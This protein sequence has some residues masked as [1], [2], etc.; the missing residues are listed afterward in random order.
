VTILYGNIQYIHKSLHLLQFFTFRLT[1]IRRHQQLLLPELARKRN[2]WCI[3]TRGNVSVGCRCR[4]P[5]WG[6]NSAPTN[7]LSGFK[8]P[9]RGGAKEKK[10]TKRGKERI[11]ATEE[12]I[13]K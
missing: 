12:N 1:E 6:A 9:L 7:H 3:K 2:Y 13:P 5:R 11:E 4:S 8:R 10:R